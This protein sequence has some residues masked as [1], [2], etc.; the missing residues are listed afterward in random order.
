MIKQGTFYNISGVAIAMARE[1]GVD[2]EAEVRASFLE[3]LD[4][5][6]DS[7]GPGETMVN[8]LEE[9]EGK[10][11]L[12]GIVTFQRRPRLEHRLEAWNL[13]N[14][15]RSI[16]T[17][18]QHS[19]FKP[20]PA[21]FLAAIK[22]LA[23]PTARCLVVGD[24]PVDMIGGRKAGAETIGLPQGFFSDEELREAGADHII[25]SL[26]ELPGLVQ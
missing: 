9:L 15:F 19:E 10:G 23:I 13:K 26:T 14:Y 7:T 21:P 25:S 24:E 2:R 18:E 5:I 22:E 1:Q 3:K 17:P 11:V 12:M 4:R 20:S 16:V 8:V 6:M